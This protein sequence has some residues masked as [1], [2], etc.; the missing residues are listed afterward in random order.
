MPEIFR[1][2]FDGYNI[3]IRKK[4][5]GEDA[6]LY[7]A[8]SQSAFLT[9]SL[10]V[11]RALGVTEVKI[12]VK[13]DEDG[14]VTEKTL[15]FATLER[16][17]DVF[18]TNLDFSVLCGSEKSG[19]FWYS[20][21]FYR[22]KDVPVL[23]SD[24]VNNLEVRLSEE[25]G[26]SFRLLVYEDGF[27]TPEYFRGGVMYHIFVDRFAKG[28]FTPPK[29]DDAV[30]ND[31]WYGGI[32]Q[33][34]E[35]PGAFVAN[36]M[37]FGGNLVGVREKLGYLFS[38]GVTVIYL[39]PVGKAYSN[40]KY[41]TGDY[42]TVDEMFGGEKALSDLIA[43]AKKYGIR[44][45]LDGV[46]NHTG[47]DSRYFNKYGKYDDIGAY[48]SEKSPYYGWYKFIEF[49]DKYESWW[50][51]PILPKLNLENEECASFLAKGEK[52]VVG[53]YVKMGIGGIR[54][55]VADELPGEF[56]EELRVT[57]KTLSGGDAVI[58]GE[59]WENASDKVAYGKR[60]K[61]LR[62]RQLDSVMNYP[63]RTAVIEFLLH[64]NAR[65]LAD[66]LTEIYASYPKC[67][68]D[69]LMNIIGTHDTERILTVLSGENKYDL[70]SEEL[71]RVRMS[72]ESRERA[73]RLLKLAAVTQFT[74]YGIPSVY[75]GDEA[76]MEG[77][78]DP[79]CRMPYPWGREDEE[80]VALYRLLGK[81]RRENKVFECGTFRVLHADGAF[82]MFERRSAGECVTVA[83]NV[84]GT[85]CA[86]GIAGRDLLTGTTLT[87]DDTLAPMKAVVVREE[88]EE[89]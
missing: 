37:F 20:F 76:G 27:D 62:G 11:P 68:S 83:L 89:I 15:E 48:Q 74:V 64:K 28:D 39:S 63:F 78:H 81:I 88:G 8:F 34:G 5:N 31:D 70:P 6:S 72:D 49:P 84:G 86:L 30:I 67:V 65:A 66:E 24:A 55:D 85:E 7:G 22:K 17:N 18:E 47:D 44:I 26:R 23:F 82:L 2:D 79:F 29:R 35:Y 41:D 87:E 75:Y 1:T 69:S 10:L 57:A 60:R 3:E 4:I 25:N 51:I 40:H 59:V 38:L 12:T 19:L 56:L 58:I 73:K 14:D 43:T 16:E 13:N 32:P 71:A 77:Y 54:L 61:Y 46:F 45:I 50:G 33:Y 80:L 52:S 42:M 36:N 53:K 9:L 21:A